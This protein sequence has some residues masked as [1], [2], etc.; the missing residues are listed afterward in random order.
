MPFNSFLCRLR[1]LEWSSDQRSLTPVISSLTRGSTEPLEMKSTEAQ[2]LDHETNQVSETGREARHI[3]QKVPYTLKP[4]QTSGFRSPD[5]LTTV[6][7]EEQLVVQ[8]TEL[9]AESFG[10]KLNTSIYP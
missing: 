7:V 9:A 1:A 3:E 10:E 4:L 8:D 6:L 2:T 5:V